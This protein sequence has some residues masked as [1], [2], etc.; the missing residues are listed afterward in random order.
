MQT[1][2]VNRA[3]RAPERFLTTVLMT[4]IVGST[5]HAA[6]LGDRVWRDL[7]QVHHATVRAALKRHGGRQVDTAGDGLV[8]NV[9]SHPAYFVLLDQLWVQ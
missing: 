5:Q 9:Q 3:Q 8:G 6:E 2:R 4:D 1:D 7:V